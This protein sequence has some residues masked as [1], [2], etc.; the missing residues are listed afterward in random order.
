MKITH[1]FSDGIRTSFKALPFMFKHKM[2]IWFLPAFFLTLALSYGA[3]AL[4]DMAVDFVDRLYTNAFGEH[5]LDVCGEGMIVM[6]CI[7][8]V[9][10]ALGSYML[11]IVVWV[12]LFWLKIK[13][14]KYVVLAFLGP[15]MSVIS[16]VT[17]EKLTGVK[18]PFSLKKFIRDVFR[19]IRTA[20][21]YL[22]IELFLAL[23]LLVVALVAGWVFPVLLPF[24]APLEVIVAFIIGAFF[25]GAA[26]LDYVWE[27]EDV[28][29]LGSLGLAYKSRR[30]A[31]GIGVP[32][33]IWMAIPIV[34]FTLAP[35]FAPALA[36]VAA[37]LALKGGEEKH[38]SPE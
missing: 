12:G 38:S 31:V 3:F 29:A 21:L 18:H 32:F 26:A 19:G 33:A 20:L 35:I 23:L 14:L 28:G 36:T 30:L 27:R 9:C 5:S 13:L 6:D 10:I 24:L 37:V 34:N 16:D 2:L 22:F 7:E 4:I 11:G 8:E 1:G 15:V 17:E 25:Y